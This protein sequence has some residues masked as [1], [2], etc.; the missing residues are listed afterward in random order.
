VK[1]D[2]TTAKAR[3]EGSIVAI[4]FFAVARSSSGKGESNESN[5]LVAPRASHETRPAF[6]FPLCEMAGHN[7]SIQQDRKNILKCGQAPASR[8]LQ[9]V[10]ARSHFAVTRK[11]ARL[12]ALP[13]SFTRVNLVGGS[14]AN[15]PTHRHSVPLAS[16]NIASGTQGVSCGLEELLKRLKRFV[17]PQNRYRY[18][19][20]K[21]EA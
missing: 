2:R 16:L 19:R 13:F 17:R 3:D 20:E 11:R 4:D 5:T 6:L 9:Y 1:D 10:F 14:W 12:S 21:R 18:R 15:Q 7:K 8:V